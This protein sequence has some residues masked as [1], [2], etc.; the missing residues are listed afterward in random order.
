MRNIGK[1]EGRSLPLRS[2]QSNWKISQTLV[3]SELAILVS[4][5]IKAKC[6]IMAK[7]GQ[8]LDYCRVKLSG[9]TLSFGGEMRLCMVVFR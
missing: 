7:E 4:K 5:K 2:L 9:K 8:S 6:L 1:T 3:K